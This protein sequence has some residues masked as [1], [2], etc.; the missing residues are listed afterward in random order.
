MAEKK[1]FNPTPEQGDVIDEKRSN[2]LVSAAAGSGKTTVLAARI[3]SEIVKH[4]L[5]VDQLLVVTFT[6]DAAAHMREKIEES[7]HDVLVK[8]P[9]SQHVERK[10]SK[11]VG[12][13]V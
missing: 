6:K 3:A 11:R 5:E 4:E 13:Y 7:L 2:I 12:S 10:C 1:E 9:A 8:I